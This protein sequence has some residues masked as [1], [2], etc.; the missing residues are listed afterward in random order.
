MASPTQGERDLLQAKLV[1]IEE[2]RNSLRLELS[3]MRDHVD[4]MEARRRDGYLV[5]FDYPYGPKVRSWDAMPGGNIYRRMLAGNEERYKNLLRVAL[6]KKDFLLRIPRGEPADETIP[7]WT[8]DWFPPLDAIGL[9]S[10]LISRNP[11]RY[12]EVGSGNSTKFARRAILDHGLRATI[13]SI[14]PHPRAVID[15]LCDRAIRLP[16]EDCDL[17]EFAD[18]GEGDFLFID[19]SHRS[20]QN[21]DVTVFFTEI[22][23]ILKSGCIFGIHDIFLPF[24]YFVSWQSRFYNEQYLLMSYLIGGSGGDQIIFPVHY[25]ERSPELVALL[26]PI[27]KNPSMT[28]TF[29]IGGAFWMQKV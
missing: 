18:L 22:L 28:D 6:E 16:L 10:L 11:R 4:Q 23:P 20:F 21:S 27:F 13:T 7:F 25:I 24:D 3:M 8:N 19:N 9:M 2:E 15:T 5:E 26:D 12:V 17:S 29:P 1:Q 14:D